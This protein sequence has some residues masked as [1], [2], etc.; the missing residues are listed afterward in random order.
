MPS[1]LLGAVESGGRPVY[2]VTVCTAAPNVLAASGGIGVVVDRGLEVVAAADTVIV[3]ST[4][5]SAR[6]R[7]GRAGGAAGGGRGGQAHRVDL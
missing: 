7:V 4:G 6:R 1:V 2:Q 3:P 5:R